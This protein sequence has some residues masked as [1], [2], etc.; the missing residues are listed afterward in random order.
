[1]KSEN[2][3]VA[4]LVRRSLSPRSLPALRLQHLLCV[5]D[6]LPP[7]FAAAFRSRELARAPR[8]RMGEPGSRPRIDCTKY[9]DVLYFCYSPVYQLN[10]LYRRGELDSCNGAF[11]DWFDCLAN[12]AKPDAAI[13]VR[14]HA[15]WCH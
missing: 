4:T 15:S 14:P 2:A 1:M 8:S 6:L 13:E 3:D 7:L 10:Q 12:K 11:R 9:F 5:L